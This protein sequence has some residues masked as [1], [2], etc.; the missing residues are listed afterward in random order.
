MEREPRL[1]RPKLADAAY[2]DYPTA[3]EVMVS[4]PDQWELVQPIEQ[5]DTLLYLAAMPPSQESA[6]RNR[7]YGLASEINLELTTYRLYSFFQPWPI[8]SVIVSWDETTGTGQVERMAD[9]KMQLRPV[10]QAQ[11]WKGQTCGLI[12]ECYFHETGRR[13]TN[14]QDELCELWQ[15]VEKDMRVTRVFT[16]PHEPTFEQG[17]TDFL[18]R[19]GYAPDRACPGWWS[20]ENISN[21]GEQ[22]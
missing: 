12:W 1:P 22:Y 13:E 7:F 15:A 20:K 21:I 2:K 19:L 8:P 18:S 17:Y 10:G 16:Q 11:I 5:G 3:S 14:W 4:F 9:L 6:R